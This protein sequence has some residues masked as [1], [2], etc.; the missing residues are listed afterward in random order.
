MKTESVYDS[1]VRVRC[2]GSAEVNTIRHVQGTGS[3]LA[4]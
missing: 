3:R 2:I 4:G 1:Q